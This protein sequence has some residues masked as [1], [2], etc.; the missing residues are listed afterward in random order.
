MSK[1][2]D[3]QMYWMNA[4]IGH[5]INTAGFNVVVDKSQHRKECNADLDHKLSEHSIWQHAVH[6]SM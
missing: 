4:L 6:E 5:N 1:L 2:F 3:N